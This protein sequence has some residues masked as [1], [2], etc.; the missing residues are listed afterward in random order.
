VKEGDYREVLHFVSDPDPDPQ[1]ISL[2]QRSFRPV[3]Y[4]RFDG[5]SV[6]VYKVMPSVPKGIPQPKPPSKLPR[7]G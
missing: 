5:A 1:M 4:E 7:Q 6:V 2:L 3:R